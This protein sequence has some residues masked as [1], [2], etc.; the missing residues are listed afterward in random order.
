LGVNLRSF[1]VQLSINLVSSIS[2]Q[3]WQKV[4]LS[5]IGQARPYKNRVVRGENVIIKSQE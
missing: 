2:W 1:N 5:A 4:K 3:V